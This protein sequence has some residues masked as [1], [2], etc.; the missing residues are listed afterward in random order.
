[1]ALSI[2]KSFSMGVFPSGIPVLS[3]RLLQCVVI[4]YLHTRTRKT[5]QISL[6][7]YQSVT[8]SDFLWMPSYTKMGCWPESPDYC[9]PQITSITMLGFLKCQVYNNP[10]ELSVITPSENTAPF[11]Q[12]LFLGDKTP[13]LHYS[14]ITQCRI[15]SPSCQH[16]MVRSVTDNLLWQQPNQLAHKFYRV[17]TLRSHVNMGD[18]YILFNLN[19]FRLLQYT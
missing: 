2:C 17:L 18:G 4:C 9:W 19:I 11:K 12:A 16:Q 8:D 13:E 10:L 6:L 7:T 3:Q 15:L 1:M 14:S 5:A